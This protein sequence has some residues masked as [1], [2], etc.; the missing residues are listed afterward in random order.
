MNERRKSKDLG[1]V[2]YRGCRTRKKYIA[3]IRLPAGEDVLY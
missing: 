3:R 2:Q 1:Q